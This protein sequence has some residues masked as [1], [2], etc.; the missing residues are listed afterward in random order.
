MSAKT[1]GGRQEGTADSLIKLT[2]HNFVFKEITQR[3]ETLL[4]NHLGGESAL[5]QRNQILT[6]D[7]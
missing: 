5:K 6:R 2:P 4:N 1:A 7:C 3:K